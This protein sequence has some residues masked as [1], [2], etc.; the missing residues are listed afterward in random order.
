MSDKTVYGYKINIYQAGSIEG[1]NQGVRDSYDIKEGF[2]VNSLF[3]DFMLNNGLKTWND[4][5]TRD[6]I[7]INFSSFNCFIY[8]NNS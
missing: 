5:S 1:V 6:I 8:F 2:L 7:T 4:K 3:L